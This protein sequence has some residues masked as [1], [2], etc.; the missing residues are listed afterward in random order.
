MQARA[1]GKSHVF[2]PWWKVV[3]YMVVTS[4]LSLAGIGREPEATNPD[5][6]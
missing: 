3:Q 2:A 4:L 1:N 5:E 6:S